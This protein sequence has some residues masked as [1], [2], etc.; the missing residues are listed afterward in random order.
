MVN[1]LAARL[2]EHPR[3]RYT[4]N[5]YLSSGVSELFSG[6]PGLTA[7]GLASED[8]GTARTEVI[9]GL[10]RDGPG[11]PSVRAEVPAQG[12]QGLTYR[13]ALRFTESHRSDLT[14]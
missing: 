8:A 1:S 11:T 14:I 12:D 3:Q 13:G 2:G 9:V 4:K 7:G 10:V 6:R 5:T